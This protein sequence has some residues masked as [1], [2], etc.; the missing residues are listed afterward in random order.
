MTL[1]PR[2]EVI[3]LDFPV[4]LA[5]RL[6]ESVTI[7]RPTM[8]VLKKHQIKGERDVEGEMK[9]FCALTGLRME[10]LEE[11]DSADYGRLQDAYVRFRN[12]NAGADSTDGAQS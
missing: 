8:G 6:L 3:Q 2:E 9:L 4:Q 7:K 1:K 12:P 10:E 11:L 5:D